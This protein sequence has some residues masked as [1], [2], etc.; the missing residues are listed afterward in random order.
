MLQYFAGE[1]LKWFVATVMGAEVAPKGEVLFRLGGSE[2]KNFSQVGYHA[3]NQ[4]PLSGRQGSRPLRWGAPRR[5]RPRSRRPARQA[6]EAAARARRAGVFYVNDCLVPAGDVVGRSGR[7]GR[8]SGAA[9]APRGAEPR[10][11]R[12]ER[13]R[14]RRTHKAHLAGAADA[15]GEHS[16]GLAGAQLHTMGRMDHVQTEK[17]R[18]PWLN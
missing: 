1:D 15:A 8:R 16:R 9:R 14:A 13:F 18:K 2:T 12:A 5:R 10:L 17:A 7:R 4:L 11:L 6:R 3:N